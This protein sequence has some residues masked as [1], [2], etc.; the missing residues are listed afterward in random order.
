MA[1]R[2]A[3][4]ATRTSVRVPGRKDGEKSKLVRER[5]EFLKELRYRFEARR[6][7]RGE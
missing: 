3:Y 5:E 1:L 7:I 4:Y 6:G 2:K